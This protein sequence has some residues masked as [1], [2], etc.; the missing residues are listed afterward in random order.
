V[1]VA[2]ASQAPASQ[3]LIALGGNLGD[4]LAAFR[5]ALRRLAE[6]GVE[7]AAVSSAYRTAALLAP[8]SQKP[9]PD[10]WNAAAR[11]HT[12]L[13][14]TDLLALLLRLEAQ[15]GR[16]RRPGARWQ[17][18]TLDLDLL[19][20]DQFVL[21]EP[22]LTLPHPRLAERLFVLRPLADIAAGTTIP[23]T[24]RTVAELLA[25]LPATTPGILARQESWLQME[26]GC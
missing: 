13:S 8:G 17:P 19:T 24:G 5:L 25:R 9:A 15:A 23:G 12:H 3:A 4:V 26:M 10:Y 20:Y 2:V 6:H 16:E 14:P 21:Q 11:L 18:R 1:S 22:T 7:V